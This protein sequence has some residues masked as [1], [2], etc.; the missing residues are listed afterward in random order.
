MTTDEAIR[1]LAEAVNY[2]LS[3][4]ERMANVSVALAFAALDAK[5]SADLESGEAGQEKG[6]NAREA[7]EPDAVNREP[8][9]PISPFKSPFPPMK[10]APASS[11]AS[12][13]GEETVADMR[14][15]ADDGPGAHWLTARDARF[16]CDSH[17]ELRHR[18]EEVVATNKDF[19]STIEELRRQLAEAVGAKQE[20]LAYEVERDHEVETAKRERDAALVRVAGL[21]QEAIRCGCRLERAFAAVDHAP[22]VCG[23]ETGPRCPHVPDC[24][25]PKAPELCQRPD[26]VEK[27]ERLAKPPPGEQD[28]GHRYDC[29]CLKCEGGRFGRAKYVASL[30]AVAKAARE[31]VESLHHPEELTEALRI[32]DSSEAVKT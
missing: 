27:R 17:E 3:G 7:E 23:T 31:Q 2:L 6:G 19:A 9:S 28:T 30:E 11:L 16:L 1:K 29:I 15:G 24:A 26:V 25:K 8:A 14:P 5:Q 10:P 13:M 20:I 18:W 22:E 12:V 4:D 32:L 21:E